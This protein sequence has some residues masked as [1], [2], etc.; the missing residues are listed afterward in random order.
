MRPIHE[1]E[2]AKDL[3]LA[4]RES[5]QM[6]VAGIGLRGERARVAMHRE[7]LRLRKTRWAAIVRE[8][9]R[10]RCPRPTEQ[11]RKQCHVLRTTTPAS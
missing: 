7:K 9:S 11:E 6:A 2:L 1:R 8:T 4:L 3:I 10:T 5:R